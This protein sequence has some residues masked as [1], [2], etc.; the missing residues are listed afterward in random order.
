VAAPPLPTLCVS[1][2]GKGKGK[3]KK[4]GKGKGWVVQL[5][6]SVFCG[7]ACSRPATASAATVSGLI[8]SP[9]GR[10]AYS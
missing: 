7:A 5:H 9:L 10:G 8:S 1:E 3:E 4:G 6:F 2:K